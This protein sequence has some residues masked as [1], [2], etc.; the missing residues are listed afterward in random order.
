MPKRVLD[1]DRT[2]YSPHIDNLSTDFVRFRIVQI[3]LA[4]L[5]EDIEKNAGRVGIRNLVGLIAITILRVLM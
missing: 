1:Y 3:R 4:A 2:L 5:W